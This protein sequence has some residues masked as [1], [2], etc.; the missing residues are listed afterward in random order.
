LELR[1]GQVGF[2][3][4]KGKEDVVWVHLRFVYGPYGLLTGYVESARKAF[5]AFKLESD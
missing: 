1:R 4:G 2:V 5:S 3:I